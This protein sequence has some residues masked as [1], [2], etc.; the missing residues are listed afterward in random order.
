VKIWYL[1]NGVNQIEGPVEV[2]AIAIRSYLIKTMIEGILKVIPPE[3]VTAK[4]QEGAGD[5]P[6]T[7]IEYL[8]SHMVDR[9]DF[10]LAD[11]FSDS[12]KAAIN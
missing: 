8:D 6:P 9:V 12:A 10:S 3:L 5:E 4:L 2:V 7:M 1:K 11:T